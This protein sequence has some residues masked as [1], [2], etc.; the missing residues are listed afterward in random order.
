[1][2]VQVFTVLNCSD[3]IFLTSTFLQSLLKVICVFGFY[4]CT[5]QSTEILYAKI[6]IP[7]VILIQLPYFYA[8]YLLISINFQNMLSL[9]LAQ[10]VQLT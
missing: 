1:M 5:T 6:Y 8:V 4:T 7:F 10:T 9:S 2:I 3:P